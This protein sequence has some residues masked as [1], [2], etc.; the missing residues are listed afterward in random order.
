[1]LRIVQMFAKPK[2]K[3]LV[4]STLKCGRGRYKSTCEY[5]QEIYSNI[6]GIPIV[7]NYYSPEER[8]NNVMY[9]PNEATMYFFATNIRPRWFK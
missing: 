7:P 2:D 6:V 9:V 5:I 1:M 4:K 8:I 3:L